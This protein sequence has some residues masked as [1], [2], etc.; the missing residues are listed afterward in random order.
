MESTKV[1]QLI[2]QKSIVFYSL[3]NKFKHLNVFPFCLCYITLP[4]NTCLE[5]SA[6]LS[7]SL[8]VGICQP[9]KETRVGNPFFRILFSKNE[10]EKKYNVTIIREKDY[11]DRR[12]VIRIQCRTMLYGSVLD[13]FRFRNKRKRMFVERIKFV[14]K[15]H[16]RALCRKWGCF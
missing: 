14:F 7:V 8:K 6:I 9:M 4:P 13:I 15:E 11:V 12:F 16:H 5:F 10:R 1:K 3:H 2:Q